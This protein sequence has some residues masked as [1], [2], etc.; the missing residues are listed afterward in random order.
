[1]PGN[2]ALYSP[3]DP[4]SVDF[5]TVWEG[6]TEAKVTQGDAER[7]E[8]FRVRMGGVVITITVM[9][10]P[11]IEEHVQG[12][13]DYVRFL[14]QS[15]PSAETDGLIDRI[16]LS[17]LDLDPA[18]RL[19]VHR[20]FEGRLANDPRPGEQRSVGRFR[21]D[22]IRFTGPSL[23]VVLPR[24]SVSCITIK[25]AVRTPGRAPE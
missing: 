17:D 21:Q 25:A 3:G 6:V 24:G 15:T 2:A 20:V 11:E 10:E 22:E 8:Q 9:P 5:F 4:P 23:D 16:G 18:A 1:M 12:F 7:P 19:A 13:A 14:H